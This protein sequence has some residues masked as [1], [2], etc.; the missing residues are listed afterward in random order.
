MIHSSGRAELCI[1]DLDGTLVDSL[2]DIAESV[3]ESLEL[4]GLR[5]IP[6][7]HYRH[8]VGEG[9]PTLCERAIGR[10]HPHLV[11]RLA[12]IAAPRY[13]T[14]LLAHTRPYPGVP[15]LVRDL[16]RGGLKLAVLSNKPHEMTTRIVRAFWNDDDF[17]IVQ[18]YVREEHRKPSPYHVLEIC[19]ALRA[20]PQR[21]WLIGDT[22]T[23]VATARAAGAGAIA[24]AWG[25]RTR[26]ELE[27]AGAD[28]IADRPEQ[29]AE[30]PSILV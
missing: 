3:N 8:L 19:A 12:E 25:F 30:V 10:T 15:E 2:R 23:D 5:P 29:V 27:S 13:R 4:L 9:F 11:K 28:F 7:P 26:A 1:F 24:A 21:T 16:R 22:P 6:L 20:S 14:R 18:G 17:A